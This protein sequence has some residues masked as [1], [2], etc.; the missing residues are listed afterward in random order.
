NHCES[1]LAPESQHGQVPSSSAP[2]REGCPPE[3]PAAPAA[4][5]SAQEAN[6]PRRRRALDR[7]IHTWQLLAA[8]V[9]VHLRARI[10]QIH[11]IVQPE[12][13]TDNPDLPRTFS[14]AC[15][16]FQGALRQLNEFDE[17][18]PDFPWLWC[19]GHTLT[20]SGPPPDLD[21]WLNSLG[22]IS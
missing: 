4:D 18:P 15:V 21:C 3:A 12:R 16:S 1:A 10:Y 2:D 5:T 14:E 11:K 17:V 7:T 9:W 19:G 8:H 22:S 6:L 20:A 13:F